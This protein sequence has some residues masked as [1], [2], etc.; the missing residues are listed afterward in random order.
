MGATRQWIPV[1][2]AL[3]LS[4]GCGGGGVG[5]VQGD[6]QDATPTLPDG[7]GCITLLAQ[8]VTTDADGNVTTIVDFAY[9]SQAN[10]I[11]IEEF[12]LATATTRR[13]T[14]FVSNALT[15]ED[16]GADGTVDRRY[17]LQ[18]DS[19]GRVVVESLDEGADDVTD[20]IRTMVYDPA[21]DLIRVEEDTDMDGLPDVVRILLY[22]PGN[23]LT[24]ELHDRQGDGTVDDVVDYVYDSGERL[25]E[26]RLDVGD[27]GQV[28]EIVKY[29]YDAEDRLFTET[30]DADGDGVPERITTHFYNTT[31]CN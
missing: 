12:D 7:G 11:R 29:T 18:R 21:G 26:R 15:E 19:A 24:T 3:V 22:A 1:L 10:L 6:S 17:H 8:S 30:L 13:V 23:V 28:D 4:A 9:D 31:I 2:L 16:D 20:R 14:Y 25:A 27:D 5:P